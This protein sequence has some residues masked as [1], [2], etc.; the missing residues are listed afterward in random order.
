MQSCRLN[1]SPQQRFVICQETVVVSGVLWLTDH[2]CMEYKYRE[3]SGSLHTW[4]NMAQVP[5]LALQ[6]NPPAV[7]N[8]VLLTP[9]TWYK[10]SGKISVG[11]TI[12]IPFLS[13]PSVWSM[14]FYHW[15]SDDRRDVVQAGAVAWFVVRIKISWI[16]SW[17]LEYLPLNKLNSYLSLIIL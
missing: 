15:Q 7:C 11:R 16:F 13:N 14:K 17:W 8:Q 4:I 6:H 9:I 10:Y 2:I 1:S 12:S 5:W 3:G